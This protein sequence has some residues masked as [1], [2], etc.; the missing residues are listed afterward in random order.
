MGALTG[1]L[2]LVQDLLVNLIG[3]K[4]NVLTLEDGTTLPL[5]FGTPLMISN[6]S[7]HDTDGVPG[8][9]FALS[10]EPNATLANETA[11]GVNIG[12]S[13]ELLK[14][15]PIVGGSAWDSGPLTLPV[16]EIEV[17]DETFAIE[18]FQPQ[19]WTF[20]VI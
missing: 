1:G 13:I 17:F 18:G 2:N 10:L 11:I 14:N 16:A 7:S 3:M 12:A 19:D 4:N 20:S 5:A 8:V 9:G 15:L 6:V